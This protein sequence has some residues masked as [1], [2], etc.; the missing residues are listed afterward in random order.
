M[1]VKDVTQPPADVCNGDD[2]LSIERNISKQAII[3]KG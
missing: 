1:S 3:E 2:V